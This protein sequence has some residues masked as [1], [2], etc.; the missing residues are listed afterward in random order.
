MNILNLGLPLQALSGIGFLW[1]WSPFHLRVTQINPIL[2][3]KGAPSNLVHRRVLTLIPLVYP[4][5]PPPSPFSEGASAES[6][7]Q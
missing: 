7:L 6:A 4:P 2:N 5:H 3:Q 1:V